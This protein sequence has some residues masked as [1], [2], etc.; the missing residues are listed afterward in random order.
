MARLCHSYSLM[1][2]VVM[3]HTSSSNSTNA[4]H[5]LSTFHAINL[6]E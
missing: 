6:S 2:Y 4:T 1:W 5:T 3:P